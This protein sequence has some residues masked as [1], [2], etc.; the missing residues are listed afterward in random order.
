MSHRNKETGTFFCGGL[1]PLFILLFGWLNPKC[2]WQKGNYGV[3]LSCVCKNQSHWCFTCRYAY[4]EEAGDDFDEEGISLTS[5][6]LKVSGD[7][8]IKREYENAHADD[9]EE[10]KRE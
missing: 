8:A 2:K 5:G 7:V 3:V 1:F 10:D 4:M 6:A 9:V